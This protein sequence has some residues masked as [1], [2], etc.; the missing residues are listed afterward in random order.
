MISLLLLYWRTI[1]YLSPLQIAWRLRRRVF[2]P[3]VRSPAS[4]GI[5][6]PVR[7]F[8]PAIGKPV[9]FL[10]GRRF[11][12]LNREAEIIR[13]ADWNQAE[14]PRL[15]LYNLHYFDFLNQ[16]RT[17]EAVGGAWMDRWISEN[18]V[19]HG[20]GWDA[21]PL[22]LRIVNWI[23]RQLAGDPLAGHQLQSLFVQAD[24]LAQ[25]LEYQ[26]RTNHLLANAKALVF[27]GLF[28]EGR[29]AA[30]WLAKGAAILQRELPEQI[31]PDGGHCERAPMYHA[32]ILEDVLDLVNFLA[33]MGSELALSGLHK[34]L[35]ACVL[36]MLGWLGQLCHPDGELSFF[37][38][39]ALGIAA[40]RDGLAAY[41]RRLGLDAPVR[42]EQVHGVS[43]LKNS[44]FF[45]IQEGDW[46]VLGDVGSVGP[47]YQPGHAHAE[48]FSFEASLGNA[49]LLV[50]SG[51]SCYGIS[52][53]RIRQRQAAAHNCL[54]VAGEDMAEVWGGHRVARRAG[55]SDVTSG[56]NGPGCW[57][58]AAH[59]GYRRIRGVGWHRRTWRVD[60]P[61]LCISDEVEGKGEQ[62]IE[63]HLHLHPAWQ[64]I[65]AANSHRF[66][67]R[68]AEGGITVAVMFED[69]LEAAAWPSTYHPEFGRS[70][71]SRK[72]IAKGYC[73]LP[74]RHVTTI[75]T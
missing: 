31:L 3:R 45:R 14:L 9:S 58:S 65:E 25:S 5:R 67:C 17:G 23:K 35:G 26:L 64:I 4:V 62:L 2:R 66:V 70:L 49:R 18:P 10:G 55:V 6:R 27:A 73:S 21:Y 41:A 63:L 19:G 33:A 57:V 7:P 39:T 74:F 59:D 34:Q 51:V 43:L 61:T 13:P 48:T 40:G 37:N 12:F 1:K 30:G 75:S 69:R 60:G 16:P 32:I 22:S 52:P 44:G 50:N 72:L 47:S 15:W 28:F 46:L 29:R 24:Y 68:K 11:R 36:P 54:T 8:A 42:A 53:E 71:P 20:A 38:D 56:L